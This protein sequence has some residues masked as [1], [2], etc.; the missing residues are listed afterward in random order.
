MITL[1]REL[2]RASRMQLFLVILSLVPGISEGLAQ[3]GTLNEHPQ[4]CKVLSI[5]TAQEGA[6]LDVTYQTRL[7]P[8]GSASELVYALNRIEGVQKVKLERRGSDQS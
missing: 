7:R 1:T 4:E 3:T 5:G 2:G 8:E 6:P